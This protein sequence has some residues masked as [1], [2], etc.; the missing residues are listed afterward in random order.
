MTDPRMIQK[1]LTCTMPENDAGAATVRDYLVKLL[2]T[3]L[4]E[5]ESFSG[6]R[7]FGNSGWEWEMPQALMDGGLV[8]QSESRKEA[9]KLIFEAIQTLR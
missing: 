1:V 9:M 4:E 3:V 8:K 7:P 2:E 6:K 5:G